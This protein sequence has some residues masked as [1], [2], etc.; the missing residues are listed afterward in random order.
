[1][2]LLFTFDSTNITALSTLTATISFSELGTTSINNY[3]DSN[4]LQFQVGA[5]QNQ[6]LTLSI[7]EMSSS[8]VEFIEYYR[9]SLLYC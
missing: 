1:M 8:E 4:A 5:N 9:W 7:E 3:D 2:E 6:S